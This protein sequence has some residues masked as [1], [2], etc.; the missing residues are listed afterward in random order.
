[1][2]LISARISKIFILRSI[3][4]TFVNA[5]FTALSAKVLTSLYLPKLLLF[6]AR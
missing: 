6:I 5:E 4:V 1:M 2:S 3:S